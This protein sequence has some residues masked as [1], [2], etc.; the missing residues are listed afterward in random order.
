M[1]DSLR[2]SNENCIP[3]DD[4]ELGGTVE[5]IETRAKRLWKV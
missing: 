1:R 4:L 3:I 2:F 5:A